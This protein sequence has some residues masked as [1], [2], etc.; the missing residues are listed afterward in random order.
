MCSSASLN[1]RRLGGDHTE[2][3]KI[4]KG[5]NKVNAHSVFPRVVDSKP[6]GHRPEVRGE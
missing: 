1:C 4:M 6:K 5:T 3:H 2:A